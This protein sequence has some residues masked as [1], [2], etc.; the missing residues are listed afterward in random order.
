MSRMPSSKGPSTFIEGDHPRG[1]A[2]KFRTKVQAEAPVTLRPSDPLP[3]PT[4]ARAWV[5][6]QYGRIVQ[7]RDTN[8]RVI[9]QLDDGW[10]VHA[11]ASKVVNWDHYLDVVMPGLKNSYAIDGGTASGK[12]PAQLLRRAVAANQALTCAGKQCADPSS[13]S[14]SRAWI[15]VAGALSNADAAPE[16]FRDLGEAAMGRDSTANGDIPALSAERRARLAGHF[17]RLAID[18]YQSS[19]PVGRGQEKLGAHDVYLDAGLRLASGSE[20]CDEKELASAAGWAT[21]LMEAAR[22]DDMTL[23][24]DELNDNVWGARSR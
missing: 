8:D 24:A 18:S 2:G 15:E 13:D 3:Y 9:V 10:Q 17:L 14:Q 11:K 19:A 22:L 6:G 21:T 12:V 1:F 4:G 16:D 7:E 23:T 5:N 20:P